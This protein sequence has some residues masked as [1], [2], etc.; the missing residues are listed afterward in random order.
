LPEYSNFIRSS[1]FCFC[2]NI[3]Y[4]GSNFGEWG[5]GLT[6]YCYNKKTNDFIRQGFP[7]GNVIKLIPKDGCV[8]ALTLLDH[9]GS[10]CNALYKIDNS[11]LETIIYLNYDNFIMSSKTKVSKDIYNW[12]DTLDNSSILNM[13]LNDNDIFFVIQEKGIY[14]WTSDNK[15]KLIQPLSINN[16]YIEEKG[17]S[18]FQYDNRAKDIEIIDNTFFVIHNLPFITSIKNN[19]FP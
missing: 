12:K 15:L 6:A 8:Y 13:T 4:I 7:T 10:L 5:G 11:K 14:K 1:T 9:M 17:E 16:Y 18:R 3:F 2:N 19:S